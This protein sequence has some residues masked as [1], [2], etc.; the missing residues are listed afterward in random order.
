VKD[1]QF[2][3]IAL[4]AATIAY[5]G[6]LN[7]DRVLLFIGRSNTQKNS[8]P[9]QELLNKLILDGYLLVWPKDKNQ[10]VSE[11]LSKKSAWAVSH[12]NR[13]LGPNERPFKVWVRRLLKGLILIPYPS[14][15]SYFV[16]WYFTSPVEDQFLINRQ[17][18][19]EIGENKSIYIM[20]HS[21][22]GITA[23]SLSNEVNI[24]GIICFGYPFKHPEKCEESYRTNYL[25]DLQKPFLIIQ[26]T[27]DEYGGKDV[28]HRYDLSP[29]IELEFV[30]ATHEYEN[31][32]VDDWGRVTHKIKS[33]LQKT[34][35]RS[36][37]C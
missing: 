20:S 33:L 12:L 17:A 35:S 5:L 22:G 1:S 28:Q 21:A 24:C 36:Y 34:H 19:Q 18:I 9:L 31:L 16:H 10:I 3:Y 11:L 25:K 4:K 2:K 14:K 30:D 26:G 8:T 32:S 7:S 37:K 23:L 13:I 6:P 15:W 27:R 29:H